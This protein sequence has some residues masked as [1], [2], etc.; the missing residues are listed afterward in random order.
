MGI[1]IDTNVFIDIENGRYNSE[2]LAKFSQFG[3]SF[4]SAITVA[5]LYL[6][7]HLAKDDATKIKREVFVES[8][9]NAIPTLAFTE[10]VAKVY[11][12]IYSIFLK[13]RIKTG[14]NAHDLQ[15]AATALAYGYPVLTSNVD[16]FK[17][18]PGIEI[19]KP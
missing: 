18:I 17:K 11:S 8:I 7:I 10:D 12:R 19:L 16:D 14:S 13:P 9:I 1:V 4:I 3:N 15:I 2:E 5:E 6:G